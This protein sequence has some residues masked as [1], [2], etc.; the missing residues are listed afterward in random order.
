MSANKKVT[1]QDIAKRAN[2]SISTVSRVINRREGVSAATAERIWE[3]IERLGDRILGRV[4]LDLEALAQLRR[5]PEFDEINAWYRGLQAAQ[6]VKI[7]M[8]ALDAG[9]RK[10]MMEFKH[11]Q[12]QYWGRHLWARGYFVASSGNV[13]DE[14][15]ME[16]IVREHK[17]KIILVV[18]HSNTLPALIGN[19]GASYLAFIFARWFAK[20]W[21]QVPNER[22]K[23]YFLDWELRGEKSIPNFPPPAETCEIVN[24]QEQMHY[25]DD[26]TGQRYKGIAFHYLCDGKPGE[27][28]TLAGPFGPVQNIAAGHVVV[29]AAHQGQLYLVLN[30]FNVQRA[31]GRETSLEGAGHLLCEVVHQLADA[32]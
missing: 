22:L 12:K 17:G 30:V 2:V 28:I 4:A 11:I 3:I 26:C 8:V 24:W 21:V 25:I 29:A 27:G 1:I 16:Y 7:C 18:G 13:T 31:A 20:D 15:I 19:M 14:A 6:V 23:Q 9:S 32:R 10:L 5:H